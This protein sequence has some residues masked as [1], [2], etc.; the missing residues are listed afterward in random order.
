MPEL[1][2]NIVSHLRRSDQA[3]LLRVNTHFLY[4]AGEALYHHLE[5]DD[6]NIRNIFRGVDRPSELGHGVKSLKAHFLSRTQ[7]V[8]IRDHDC[9]NQFDNSAVPKF[10]PS[11][12]PNVK[13]LRLDPQ[14]WVKLRPCMGTSCGLWAINR[15]KTVVRNTRLHPLEGSLGFRPQ[16]DLD[17][18][19]LFLPTRVM[20]YTS[21]GPAF[22]SATSHGFWKQDA[23]RVGHLKLVFH[24]QV[25]TTFIRYSGLRVSRVLGRSPWS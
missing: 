13:V 5:I 8:T 6:N 9:S 21:M 16:G 17:E 2:E 10:H 15:Q 18:A 22:I 20:I 12:L 1:L 3:T 4:P 25:E 24:P 23:S 11:F 19:T 7:V 14:N